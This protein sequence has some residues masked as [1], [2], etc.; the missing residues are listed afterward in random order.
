VTSATITGSTD[1]SG[2]VTLNWSGASANGRP[3]S[4]YHITLSDG[5]QKDVGAVATTTM[6]GHVGTTYTFTIVTQ[7]NRGANSSTP[8]TSSNSAV[9]KPGPPSASAGNNHQTVTFTWGPAASTEPVSYVLTGDGGLASTSPSGSFSFTG[10]YGTTY[11]FTVTA[12]SAGQ[13]TST[14]ASV[15]PV[16]PYTIQ[17]CHGSPGPNGWPYLGVIWSGNNGVTHTIAFPG[18]GASTITFS[19]ASGRQQSG[20]YHNI[21]SPGDNNYN[22]TITWT[23]NGVT[24]TTQP[25]G[26]TPAC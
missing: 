22:A 13:S 17:L 2:N 11:S 24:H 8:A 14:S 10:S 5:T 3:I 20:A 1:G 7:N 25:W 19:A 26:G 4:G 21:G 12:T 18:T 6:P 15:K 23:D 16:D 9:P